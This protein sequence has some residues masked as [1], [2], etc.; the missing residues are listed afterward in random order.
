MRF[1]RR[2]LVLWTLT[3]LSCQA[4][5]L[6]VTALVDAGR[7]Q[8]GKT[9]VEA[10]PAE[11][12][13]MRGVNGEPCP[14]HRGTHGDAHDQD[15]SCTLRSTGT[16]SAMLLGTVFSAPGVLPVLAFASFAVEETTVTASL[17]PLPTVSVLLDTPP[18][19]S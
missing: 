13:P 15:G 19:R 2:H 16:D 11:Q 14:M 18:P 17:A 7:L 8:T 6:S 1:I 9:C 5:S 4:A 10:G 12:C 3:W